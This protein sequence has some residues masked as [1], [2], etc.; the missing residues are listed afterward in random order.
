MA[1]TQ[2]AEAPPAVSEAQAQNVP[3]AAGDAPRGL[4]KQEKPPS[5]QERIAAA[6]RKDQPPPE[7][8]AAPAAEQAPEPAEPVAAKAPTESSSEAPGEPISEE[9]GPDPDQPVTLSSV[10]ELAEHIGADPAE[11]YNLAVPVQDGSKSRTVTLGE[12]KDAYVEA[13]A[14]RVD[15]KTAKEAREAA[16][17]LQSER[18]TE[19]EQN[20][21]HVLQ[22]ANVMQNRALQE[23]N[24]ENMQNLRVED[25]GAWAAKRQEMQERLNEINNVKAAAVRAYGE[26][27]QKQEQRKQAEAQQSLQRETEALLQRLP[28]WRDEDVMRQEAGEIRSYLTDLGFSETEVAEIKDHRLI[29]LARKA[30]AHDTQAEKVEVAKKKAVTI[31]AKTTQRPGTTQSKEVARQERN[32][33]LRENL[34]KTGKLDAAAALIS[35]RR[36]QRR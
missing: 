13:E 30:R 11:L 31:A 26:N 5:I 36:S 33:V 24:H 27:K 7:A 10:K 18:T 20:L 25:P 23:F 22:L 4:P 21:A 2:G 9:A 8:E 14:T 19:W 1:E 6:L 29:L 3:P 12:L 32:A 15:R 34:K 28:A 16:E 17:K 35:A